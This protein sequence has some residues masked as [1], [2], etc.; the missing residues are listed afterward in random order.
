MLNCNQDIKK[1]RT[2]ITVCNQQSLQKCALHWGDCLYIISEHKIAHDLPV[3]HFVLGLQN[4]HLTD[5]LYLYFTM[6]LSG[7]KE[8]LFQLGLLY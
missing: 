2:T 4:S 8:I 3:F 5:K 6:A 1:E 7:E